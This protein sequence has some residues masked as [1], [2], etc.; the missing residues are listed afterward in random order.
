MKCSRPVNV[1]SYVGPPGE[2][3][4]ETSSM[5]IV[6]KY[7]ATNLAIRKTAVILAFLMQRSRERSRPTLVNNYT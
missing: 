7:M 1:T 3:S 4:S 6:M 5:H 2:I